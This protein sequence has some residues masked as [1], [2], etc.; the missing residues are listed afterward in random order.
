MTTPNTITT[1][2]AT[3][4]PYESLGTIVTEGNTTIWD[5]TAVPV[6]HLYDYVCS[7]LGAQQRRSARVNAWDEAGNDLGSVCMYRGPDGL[8]CAVGG[9]MPDAF[10]DHNLEGDTPS[11]L[12]ERG[13]LRATPLG[14]D[15]L[16]ALQRAHDSRYPAYADKA[17]GLHA[18]LAEIAERFDLD[19]TAACYISFWSV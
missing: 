1:P 3:P 13:L 12:V 9:I 14:L 8:R 2:S 16:R 10:Y 15:L 11:V 6:Q 5:I 7:H 18:E 19:P 17:A 4:V